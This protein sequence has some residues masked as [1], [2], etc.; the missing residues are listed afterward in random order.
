MRGND[1]QI[2]ADQIQEAQYQLSEDIDAPSPPPTAAKWPPDLWE[3]MIHK[4]LNN[5][6]TRGRLGAL[7]LMAGYEIQ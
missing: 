7:A 6:E 2:Q 4:Y 1:R 5:D 3:V